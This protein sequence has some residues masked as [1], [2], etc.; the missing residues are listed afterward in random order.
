MYFFK[1]LVQIYMISD[2]FVD[3]LEYFH[4]VNGELAFVDNI[5]QT[6]HDYVTGDAN[7]I[8]GSQSLCGKWE[9][10]KLNRFSTD[11]QDK[12]RQIYT[13]YHRNGVEL[14]INFSKI[15]TYSKFPNNLTIS[16]ADL[17]RKVDPYMSTYQSDHNFPRLFHHIKTIWIRFL[18]DSHISP[19]KFEDV[20]VIDYVD[21]KDDTGDDSDFQ[22][23]D[24]V[25]AL[26]S[27]SD[28]SNH[29]DYFPDDISNHSESNSKSSICDSTYS[30]SQ[31][32]N[33]ERSR[34]KRR[35]E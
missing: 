26:D 32:Q 1:F 18:S 33:S 3:M 22:S 9:G 6:I 19:I 17:F 16:N 14:E 31:Y 13:A 28:D 4:S 20:T 2:L 15:K 5:R 12:L 34:K 21:V 7:K 27:S 30:D 8:F 11:L 24:D 29:S 23:C 10:W 25:S 35:T